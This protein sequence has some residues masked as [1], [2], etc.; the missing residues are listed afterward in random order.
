MLL[1][2]GQAAPEFTLPDQTGKDYSLSDWR[3]QYVL[4]YFYPKD[5][6]PGCTTEACAIR[7]QWDE[8]QKYNA[9]VIGISTDS[10]KSHDKF[11]K[12]FDLPF[13]LLSDVEKKVVE[14]YGVWGLKKFMGR[15]YQGTKR[16]SFLVD[17]EGKIAVIYRS[18]KP[19]DHASEVL[20][21]LK[22]RVVQLS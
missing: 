15:E 5:D 22:K 16:E 14:E 17:P 11:V 21:E 4:L 2:V 6:T 12:K 7:D 10:V 19:V 9:A 20:A 8:F 13:L 1:T 18:V 3:G